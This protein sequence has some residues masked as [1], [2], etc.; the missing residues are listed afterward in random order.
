V[1][2]RKGTMMPYNAQATLHAHRALWSLLLPC[3]VHG[4]VTDI[5][6]SYFA[7]RLLWDIGLR[8]AFTTPW[9]T[10]YRNAHNYL[11]DFNSEIPLYQQAG[12]LVSA[13]L[14]WQP[15]ARSIPGRLE[16]LYIL[17]YEMAI[18][19]HNDVLLVQ[20]WISDMLRLGYAFPALS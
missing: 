7:Q 13:L 12:A 19:G 5:W 1:S 4:R 2:L 20:A 16:E 11:A 10:Q 15:R 18:L 8:I 17:M 9:V 3:T 6:R 14:E